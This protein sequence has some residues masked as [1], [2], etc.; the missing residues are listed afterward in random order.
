MVEYDA[1]V[2]LRVLVRAGAVMDDLGI[3]FA[4]CFGSAVVCLAERKLV[5]SENLSAK[6]CKYQQQQRLKG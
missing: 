2:L 5:R 1:V 4:V 3:N 6:V